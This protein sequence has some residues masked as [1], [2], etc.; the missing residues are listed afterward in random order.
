M[1]ATANPFVQD[2]FWLLDTAISVYTEDGRHQFNLIGRNVND[3]IYS[4]GSGAIPGRCANYDGAC[5]PTGAN[6]LDQSNS[7]QLGRTITLQ[8]RF[9][10]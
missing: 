2:S 5:N 10:L 4:I 3:E 7:T 6:D 1:S 9:T 8:Y